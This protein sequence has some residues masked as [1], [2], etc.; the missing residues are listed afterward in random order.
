MQANVYVIYDGCNKNFLYNIASTYLYIY[1]C[2]AH[3]N[4]IRECVIALWS[5]P[6]QVTYL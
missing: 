6:A 2:N 4:I 5:V 1:I 3:N